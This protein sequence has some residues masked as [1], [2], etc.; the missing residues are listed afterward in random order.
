[1]SD[2]TVT[3]R[4]GPL[5]DVPEQ[6]SKSV[7]E[8]VD[9]RVEKTRVA[10]TAAFIGLMSRRTYDRIRVS[11]ITRK[12]GVGRGTFYAH[13]SSKD[14]LLRSELDRVVLPMVVELREAPFLVD[15]TMLF[16][17]IQHGRAIYRS[18]T[19]GASR[20]LTERIV[21]DALEHRLAAIVAQRR[22]CGADE[23]ATPAFAARFVASTLLTLIAW[24]LEQAVSP[25]PVELQHT[26]QALVGGALG[27]GPKT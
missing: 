15:C 3:S 18:L 23:A 24:S 14:D 1:M 7:P 27:S 19:A 22:T 16:A 5:R 8:L 4:R 11:D 20:S 21:Q 12:A 9:P 25:A 13:F 26:F 6:K 17:H 2:M 10:L